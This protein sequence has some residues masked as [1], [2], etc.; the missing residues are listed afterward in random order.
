MKVLSAKWEQWFLLSPYLGGAYSTEHI[1][2]KIE[3][4]SVSISHLWSEDNVPS[5][6]WALCAQLAILVT[7]IPLAL[8]C[9][10][11]PATVQIEKIHVLWEKAVNTK[12]PT[13]LCHSAPGPGGQSEKTL[14]SFP[15]HESDSK[16]EHRKKAVCVCAHNERRFSMCS[17]GSVVT[18]TC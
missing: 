15:G 2:D 7:L 16:N 14:L 10:V 18:V 12:G 17:G 4:L 6:W 3:H 9:T 8:K 5:T 1:I 11:L 13:S